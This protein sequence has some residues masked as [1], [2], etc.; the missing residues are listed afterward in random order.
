MP[1]P[2]EEM[3]EEQKEYEAQK[4]VK[5][6]DELSRWVF[7]LSQLKIYVIKIV[8]M[9]KYNKIVFHNCIFL[10]YILFFILCLFFFYIVLTQQSD[11]FFVIIFHCFK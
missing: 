7:I 10:N 8:K 5:M 6:I 3:T 2:M 1:N 11:L 9:V 4:L